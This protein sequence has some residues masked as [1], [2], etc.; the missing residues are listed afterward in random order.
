MTVVYSDSH[1]RAIRYTITCTQGGGGD[2]TSTTCRTLARSRDDAAV[3]RERV[4]FAALRVLRA[5]ERLVRGLVRVARRD[6]AYKEGAPL[7]PA[8]LPLALAGV[9]VG[10]TA[11]CREVQSGAVAQPAAGKGGSPERGGGP[12]ELAASSTELAASST[13]LAASPAS[14]ELAELAELAARRARGNRWGRPEPRRGDKLT[15]T[16][17][18]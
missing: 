2:S 3:F 6:L 9:V 5:R 11:R 12:S 13:E 14:A 18:L 4:P 15:S 8:P 1:V 16:K 17:V 10:L 7:A